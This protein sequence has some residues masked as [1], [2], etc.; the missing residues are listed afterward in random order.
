MHNH[1]PML[2]PMIFSILPATT[3]NQQYLNISSNE[4]P[5][6]PP[7]YSFVKNV[8]IPFLSYSCPSSQKSLSETYNHTILSNKTIQPGLGMG[9]TGQSWTEGRLGWGWGLGRCVLSICCYFRQEHSEIKY[10][11]EL[12]CIIIH[13]R[14]RQQITRE[15]MGR[16]S[17]R[18]RSSPTAKCW[19]TG[20]AG[21]FSDRKACSKRKHVCC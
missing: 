14:V 19:T 17:D 18:A 11:K 13:Y 1:P 4:Q 9:E 3:C 5:K 15:R 7:W 12:N 20:R 16:P 8:I 10:W 6:S 21:E 2:L